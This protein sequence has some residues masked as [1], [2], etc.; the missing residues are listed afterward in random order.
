MLTLHDLN[1]ETGIGARAARNRLICSAIPMVHAIANQVQ[2]M[3]ARA[4]VSHEELVSC[5]LLDVVRAA[6]AFDAR[7]GTRFSTFAYRWIRGGMI[8]AIRQAR[9]YHRVIW[10]QPDCGV[11]VPFEAEEPGVAVL[12]RAR[13]RSAVGALTVRQRQIVELLYKGPGTSFEAVAKVLG[14][15]RPTVFRTNARAIRTLR[16]RL[17]QGTGRPSAAHGKPGQ[18]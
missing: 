13:V 16:S 12:D 1:G 11:Q 15:K 17:S 5:G 2:R 7:R 4:L 6:D 8:D 9:D 3:Q 14:V 18:I 10:F